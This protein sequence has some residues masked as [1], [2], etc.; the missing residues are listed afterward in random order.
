MKRPDLIASLG[1]VNNR[2]QYVSRCRGRC[3]GG[4]VGA[5]PYIFLFK[6]IWP[7][8]LAQYWHISYLLYFRLQ[9][10]RHSHK[11]CLMTSEA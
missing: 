10:A 4:V 7:R 8:T 11:R 5:G 2:I 9:N 1:L 3:A 6:Y